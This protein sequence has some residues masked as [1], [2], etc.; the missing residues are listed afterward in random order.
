[1]NTRI[2]VLAVL[3]LVTLSFPF[4]LLRGDVVPQGPTLPVFST[5]DQAGEV[6]SC[7]CPKEDY[8]GTTRKAAFFDT[9][10]A[11]G[12]EFVL[13]DAGDLSPFDSLDAQGRLKAETLARAMATQ[14]Y[15]G[16]MLGDDDL[17]PGPDFVRQLVGWLGQ[18]VVATNY[19]LPEGVPAERSRVVTV[20]GHRVGILG[21][22]DP[23]LAQHAAPWVKTQPWESARA[24]VKALR[25]KSDLLVAMA[26]APDTT[27]V[28]RL[29]KLYPEI[30][31]VIGAHE[32]KTGLALTRIGKTYLI[33]SMAKGRFVTRV[34]VA[35]QPTGR[36]Q[37]MTAAFLP[38][39]EAWGRRA[40]V[41]SLL[42]TYYREVKELTLSA[43][44][45]VQREASL[46]EPPVAF[47]GTNA[48]TSCHGA[49]S[50]QW[51][52]TFHSHAHET[53]VKSEKDHDPE[54]QACHTTGF[55]FKT[56]FVAP[57]VT[58]DRWEVGCES[59][60]GGGAAHIKD[61]KTPYGQVSETTCRGCH[62]QD[63]SP[64]FDYSTYLPKITH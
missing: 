15:D 29:A 12:W 19:T 45:V 44:Y 46:R 4:G 13:V 8:G 49:Q 59:C 17:A 34:E 38:V 48:C 26:H 11:S 50:T 51:K 31:L 1:M 3:I 56:G 32:G 43:D 62:T 57:S 61:P 18:P 52:T 53:L 16:I 37:Q 30:D 64:D 20:R 58:P 24:E 60:H 10:R 55:G 41:D 33:G 36:V 5:G 28:K 63:R 27:S 42:A 40:K 6:A 23:G 25:Q 21:F 35:F 9:L 54:C 47:V 22:L 14:G 7:G 2:T 39:V